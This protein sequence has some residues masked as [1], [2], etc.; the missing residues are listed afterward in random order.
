MKGRNSMIEKTL[1]E[2]VSEA[3]KLTLN[4]ILNDDFVKIQT[5]AGNA[6][7]ISEA[8]WDILVDGMKAI[9]SA[10]SL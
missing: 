7:L 1:S 9:F 4:A 8:E 2:F 3:E 5:A 6:V 10:D